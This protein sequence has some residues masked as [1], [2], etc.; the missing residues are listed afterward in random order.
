MGP[1][2]VKVPRLLRI[3]DVVELTGIERWRLGAQNRRVGSGPAEGSGDLSR[4]GPDRV[5]K[6][7]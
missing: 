2:D 5:A 1:N 4:L 3:N 7:P 6:S